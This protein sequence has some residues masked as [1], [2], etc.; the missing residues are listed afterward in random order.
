MRIFA[1]GAA[2][3]ITLSAMAWADAPIT[4]EQRAE[5]ARYFGFDEFHTYR[6]E[7]GLR[8]LRLADVNSDGRTDIALWSPRKNR[9]ELILQPDP[10][11]PPG[12]SDGE[13]EV[14]E[15]PNRGT[16]VVEHLPLAER[17]ATFD[18]AD[19]T[20]DGRNDLVLLTENKEVVILP[21]EEGGTFGSPDSVRA[22][23]AE[24]AG[25]RMA[26]GDFNHDGRADVA[27][28]GPDVLL[29]FMQE[30]GGGLAQPTRVAHAIKQPYVML[31]S[32]VNGDGRDDLALS[33]GDTQYGISVFLQRPEGGLGSMRR[34]KLPVFRSITFA[35]AAGGSDLFAIENASGRLFHYRWGMPEE[36]AGDPDWPVRLYSYSLPTKAK[37]RPTG[38]GDVN[39]DGQPDVVCADPDAARMVLFAQGEGGLTNAVDFPAL[40][41]TLDVQIVDLDG[42]GRKEVLSVSPTEKVIG[43][44]RYDDGR[45]TYPTPLDVKGDPLAATVLPAVD[46]ERPQLVAFVRVEDDER[47]AEWFGEDAAKEETLLC[48]CDPATGEHRQVLAV[49]PPREDPAA[50]RVA[51]VNQDGRHDLLMFVPYDK[52]MV[53]LQQED[54][55]FARFGGSETREGLVEDAEVDG[56]ALVDVDGDGPAELVLTQ[57]NLARALA[58]R[59]GRWT[60]VDQYNPETT[61]AS[62]GGVVAINGDGDGPTLVVYDRG[63]GNLIAFQRRPDQTYAVARTMPV[64][65]F[66]TSALLPLSLGGTPAIAIADPAMLAV[67]RPAQVAP[68]LVQQQ[69]YETDTKDGWLGDAVPGDVNHDGIRDVVV[70]DMR[71]AN[72]EVL[73]TLPDGELVRALR[74]QVYQGKQFSDAPTG[75]LGDVLVG[76]VTGDGIDDVVTLVHDRALVYPGQ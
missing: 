33:T 14:N 39:G 20:D 61:D 19:L 69:A 18:V 70:V 54:G 32:D 12:E 50:L 23:E 10:N 57:G 8:S 56:Y 36:A 13:L 46:G 24:G 45:L 22:P 48:L 76:D 51:D 25:G 16:L 21:G 31:A 38:I 1:I 75:G 68:T 34:V 67:V 7:Y 63:A 65:D 53:F 43:V 5:L 40:M 28:L 66:G 9:L 58:I 27:V 72:L 74:F 11:A 52:L 26:L 15:L 3:L 37:R 6:F 35:E 42:D 17:V 49:E 59:A 30:E 47:R 41:K 2:V 64:G 29:I 60:V 4:D 62:L 73:T 44:S 55:R 71:K